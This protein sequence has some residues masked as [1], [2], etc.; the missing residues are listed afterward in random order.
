MAN[1]SVFGSILNDSTLPLSD[2]VAFACRFLPSDDLRAFLQQ[3]ADE[4]EQKGRLEGLVLTGLNDNG[5]RLLQ[6]YLDDTG[7]IQTLAILAARL[8]AAYVDNTVPLKKWITVYQDV[9]NEWQ[10]FHQRARFDVRRTEFEDFL[11]NFEK[12]AREPDADDLQAEL[13]GPSSPLIPPQLHVRC[14]YCSTSLSLAGLLRLGGSHSSWLSKAKP[15]VTCCPSCHKPLPQC[16]LCLL[17]FGSLNPY[18]ELAHRRSKQTADSVSGALMSSS[19]LDSTGMLRSSRIVRDGDR[20]ALGQ[21]SSIPFVEWFTWCQACK[22]GGHAHHLADWFAEHQTCPVTDC[23]CRCR[24][25]DYPLI[26]TAKPYTVNNENDGDTFDA[27]ASM[28][29]PGVVPKAS[30]PKRVGATK[31]LSSNQLHQAASS[32]GTAPNATSSSFSAFRLI[33]PALRVSGGPA[34]SVASS[35]VTGAGGLEP[36]SDIAFDQESHAIRF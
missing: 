34:I 19:A 9:L 35:A 15:K 14:N 13:S 29:V 4:C 18:F 21:L 33:P 20:E 22:H 5:V 3:S 24:D 17:P 10:L 31:V 2:R 27:S 26:S 8:P 23:D 30:L 36:R 12:L 16:A 6:K 11:T 25:L 32:N 28:P 1:A 7:D